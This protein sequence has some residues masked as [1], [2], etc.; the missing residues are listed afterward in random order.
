MNLSCYQRSKIAYVFSIALV[1]HSPHY[2][3][4][5]NYITIQMQLFSEQ[6]CDQLQQVV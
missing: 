2:H 1:F 4:R 5:N 3:Q 6:L